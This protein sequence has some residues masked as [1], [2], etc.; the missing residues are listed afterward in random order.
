MGRHLVRGGVLIVE[1]FGLAI[2]HAAIGALAAPLPRLGRDELRTLD[3]RCAALP[4]VPELAAM[5][6]AEREWYRVFYAPANPTEETPAKVDHW[7]A[8]TARLADACADPAALAAIRA[9]AKP[10]S[11]EA[12]F[13]DSF[14]AYLRA[15]TYADVKRAML[16]AAVAIARDGS[17]AVARVPDPHDGRTFTLRSWGTGFELTSRFALDGKPPAS[18]VVGSR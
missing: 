6:R 13:L 15:R 12:K 8:W 7:S 10:E 1:L 14:D 17:G 5:V 18:L 9:E 2:E 16:R 11:D 4:A 3:S